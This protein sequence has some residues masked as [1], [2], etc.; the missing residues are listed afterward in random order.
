MSTLGI[1]YHGSVRVS[2]LYAAGAATWIYQ[3]RA[4]KT[5]LG[6]RCIRRPPAWVCSVARQPFGGSCQSHCVKRRSNYSHRGRFISQGLPD[7]IL[8]INNSIAPSLIS[9]SVVSGCS[10]I[11][12]KHHVRLFFWPY[13]Y[14]FRRRAFSEWISEKLFPFCAS[15]ISDRAACN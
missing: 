7:C 8:N 14:L 1:Q 10:A 12:Q 15:R 5:D 2:G 6:R 13:I 9:V 11:C 4:S 3:R